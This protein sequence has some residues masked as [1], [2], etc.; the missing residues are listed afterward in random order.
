VTAPLELRA[1]ADRLTLAGRLRRLAGHAQAV[2]D[3]G[4]AA[5]SG[6]AAAVL[7]QLTPAVEDAEV[8][9]LD[10]EMLRAQ[11]ADRERARGGLQAVRHDLRFLLDLVDGLDSETVRKPWLVERLA[12]TIGRL[13]ESMN[14]KGKKATDE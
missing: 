8:Q 14:T 11:A 12:A 10:V 7:G 1:P 6:F 13:D 4:G 5:E 3:A 2:A 9:A